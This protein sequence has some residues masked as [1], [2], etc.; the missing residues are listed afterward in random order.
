M[1]AQ[2]PVTPVTM[3]DYNTENKPDWCPGCGDFGILNSLKKALVDLQKQP[4][5]V[6]VIAGIGCSSKL[7]HWLNAYGFH[8]LHGR[9]LPIATAVRLANTKNDV[10]VISGDGDGYGIGVG[11][12]VHAA[13]RN[14]NITMLAHNNQI[15]GLT[16]G[17]AS[18]TTDLGHKTKTT[19]KGN[20]EAPLNPMTLAIACGAGMVARSSAGDPKHLTETIKEAMQYRGFS[21]I[22]ILQP[23]V[24]FNKINTYAWYKE[25]ATKLPA[26]WDPTDKAKAFEM[27]LKWGHN[28]IALGTL[29][30]NTKLPTLEDAYP[31]LVEKPLVHHDLRVD[32][33][34]SLNSYL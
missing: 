20:F 22:D 15:Y 31:W 26:D 14:V 18:P 28:D 30:K 24:T 11:H 23:C 3:K 7:P 33:T 32:V 13:R 12:L 29:Y 9:A 25:Q 34:K 4:H 16:T 17:Q 5:E 6:T 27:A 19:P 8:T 21:L 2:L 10:I 1:S